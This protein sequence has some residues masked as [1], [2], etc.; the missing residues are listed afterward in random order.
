MHFAAPS[1]WAAYEELPS[2]I[3][4][5]ADQAFKLLKNNPQHPSVQFKQVGRYWSARVDK[6][7]R[8]LAVKAPDGWVWFWIGPHTEYDRQLR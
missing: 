7:F 5:H 4:K 1:F 6:N 2:R 3:Q 8:A